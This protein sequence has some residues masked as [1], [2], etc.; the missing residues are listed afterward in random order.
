MFAAYCPGAACVVLALST[1]AVSVGPLGA[2][3]E[4]PTGMS[5]TKDP[6]ERGEVGE[7]MWCPAWRGEAGMADMIPLGL[8]AGSLCGDRS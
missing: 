2:D 8:D 1:E 5:D 3:V 7:V 4:R 6:I